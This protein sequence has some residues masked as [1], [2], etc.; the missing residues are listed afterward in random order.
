MIGVVDAYVRNKHRDSAGPVIDTFDVN[1]LSASVETDYSYIW[2]HGSSPDDNEVQILNAFFRHLEELVEH[3]ENGEMIDGII[4]IL[5]RDAKSA[6]IWAR[7]LRLGA[8]HPTEFGVKLRALAWAM[9]L[10]R[11]MDSERDA[12]DFVSV[13]F[14]FLSVEERETVERAIIS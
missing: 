10:L 6:V 12:G 5:I 2:D 3:P 9:P 1:G 11:A 7:L 8:L 14:P 13:I 4:A